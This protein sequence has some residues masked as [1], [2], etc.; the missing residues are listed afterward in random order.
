MQKITLCGK[1]YSLRFTVNALCCLEE[2]M[3]C[4]LEKILQSPLTGMRGLLWCGMMED[5][6]RMTLEEAGELMERHLLSGGSMD[7]LSQT[8]ANGLKDAGFFPKPGK[9][10]TMENTKEA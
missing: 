1:E 8:L 7:S 9:K 3:G 5:E 10:D 6:P 2:K 4:G